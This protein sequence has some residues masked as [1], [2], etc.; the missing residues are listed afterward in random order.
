MGRKESTVSEPGRRITRNRSTIKDSSKKKRAIKSKAIK[1]PASS[2]AKSIAK[3]KAPAVASHERGGANLKSRKRKKMIR[4]PS[5]SDSE[6]SSSSL[7]DSLSSPS[8]SSSSSS[9]DDITILSPSVRKRGLKRKRPAPAKRKLDVSKPVGKP[10]RKKVANPPRPFP[11]SRKKILVKGKAP[12]D[13]EAFS[14]GQN[15]VKTYHV[16]EEDDEVWDCMLNQAN[17]NRNNN[18]FYRLQVLQ[19]DSDAND[20]IVWMRWG[21][22]GLRGQTA[23]RKFKQ[24]GK[25]KE[26]FMD[27][28]LDKTKNHWWERNQF[29]AAEGKYTLL[30]MDYETPTDGAKKPSKEEREPT[31]ESKLPKQVKDLISLIFDM[32]MMAQQMKELE[33]DANKMPLG[34]LTKKTIKRGYSILSRIALRLNGKSNE[35]ILELS[36]K[37]YTY[38]PHVVGMKRLPQIRSRQLLRQKVAL[39]NSL[40]EIEIAA[41][42]IASNTKGGKNRLDQNYDNLHCKIT[43][44][45][46]SDTVDMIKD[47]TRLTHAKTHDGY[48]LQVDEVFE[49]SRMGEANRFKPFEKIKNR[50]LLWHGSRLTNWIGILSQG[51]RIAPPEAP[52]TGYMFGKGVYFADMC[53]KGANYCFTSP[54]SQT[55]IMLLCEVALGKMNRLRAADYRAKE[56]LSEGMLSTMGVGKTMPDPSTYRT[57]KN[58]CVVPI[59]KSV[60]TPKYDKLGGELRYNE[61]IV[62]DTSQVKMKYLVR[63]KFIYN[64]KKSV[65]W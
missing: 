54:E 39:I 29:R 49:I 35:S 61:Y 55:G 37:F 18:K 15:L 33:Y 53:S 23:C 52:V 21:R 30:H 38:I 43:P 10:Q 40:A 46:N 41:S 11:L 6:S 36:N 45:H 4:L 65:S 50:M 31:P 62:Y 57:L 9:S 2:R 8:N 56:K 17:I 48:T 51:L 59:G 64:K 3:P 32:E 58:G 24:I 19:K 7:S 44:C 12:V 28:F 22:V 25:A 42:L 5:S 26:A 27:K 47:Y 34:K 1:K 20:F 63:M 14:Q 16:L 13:P 60:E